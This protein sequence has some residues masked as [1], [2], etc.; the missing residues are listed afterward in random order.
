MPGV[1][2]GWTRRRDLGCEQFLDSNQF[3]FELATH[4]FGLLNREPIRH[5]WEYDLM[6]LM[7][8]PIPWRRLPRG[9]GGFKD[10]NKFKAHAVRT[11]GFPSWRITQV[12]AD[13]LVEKVGLNA[14]AESLR[15]T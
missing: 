3:E 8:S 10:G 12:E 5:L 2:S 15:L 1:L 11:Y 4:E 9:L 13:L 14:H 7:R 6:I